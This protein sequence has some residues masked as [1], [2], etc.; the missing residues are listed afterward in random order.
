MTL[1][2]TLARDTEIGRMLL[3][4]VESYETE[5]TTLLKNLVER[6]KTGS[7]FFLDVGS[8][9]GYFPLIVNDYCHRNDVS[10]DCYAHEPT[11]VLYERAI[12]LQQANGIFY[13]LSNRMLGDSGVSLAPDSI[14]FPLLTGKEYDQIVI[15]INSMVDTA[16]VLAG[17]E[18][19]IVKFRPLIVCAAQA[20]FSQAEL[21]SFAT[22][23]R[24][25]IFLPDGTDWRETSD[26]SGELSSVAHFLVPA[27]KT[28]ELFPA[29]KAAKAVV[30]EKSPDRIDR[31][32]QRM[33][34]LEQQL[35]DTSARMVQQETL[36][37][38][39]NK[40]IDFNEQKIQVGQTNLEASKR[41]VRTLKKALEDTKA[42]LRDLQQS[43][44]FRAGHALVKASKSPRS[45]LRLPA[46]LLRV[47]KDVL[48]KRQATKD[49][50]PP[51]S[52]DQQKSQSRTFTFTQIFP[53]DYVFSLVHTNKKVYGSRRSAF[54]TV[55]L[56]EC[57]DLQKTAA[58]M[59]INFNGEVPFFYCGQGRATG[60][61]YISRTKLHIEKP[62][63]TLSFTLNA[64]DGFET[65]LKQATFDMEF[66]VTQVKLELPAFLKRRFAGEKFD[67][68]LYSDIWLNRNVDGSAVWLA[69]VANTL[70]RMGRVLMLLKSEDSI[71]DNIDPDADITYLRPSDFDLPAQ[72][73]NQEIAMRAIFE[74]DRLL[75]VL[76]RVVVRGTRT[77]ELLTS[78]R[79]FYERS[80]VYLTDFYR[81]DENGL[82]VPSESRVQ[83]EAIADNAA[84]FLMQTPEIRDL[85]ARIADRPI[86]SKL[87]PPLVPDD[88]SARAASC[89]SSEN[90]EKPEISICYAGKIACN[91]GIDELIDWSAR[92]RA[93]GMKLRVVII[94]GKFHVPADN[95]NYEWEM[96]QRIAEAGIELL[97]SMPRQEALDM[98]K[99]MDYAWCY[100]PAAL[101]ESTIEVSCKL[102]ESVSLGCRS[103]CYPNR[104][105]QELLGGDYPY[106]IG[107]FEE[108]KA[109]L[110]KPPYFDTLSLAKKVCTAHSATAI[111]EE[112]APTLS[113]PTSD[114]PRLLFAGHDFKF[115][116][117]FISHL[118]GRGNPVLV[119]EW[120]WG[121]SRNK[122]MDEYY[123]TH[124]EVVFCEWG[125]ANAVWYSRRNTM[126][127][128][129]FIRAHLQ[130]INRAAQKFGQG[131][132]IEN[133]TRVIFVSDRVR[134]QAIAMWGWPEEKTVV[135]PNFVLDDQF[136][137][138]DKDFTAPV[139]N[140]GMI[141]ITPQ[142]KRF[143]RAVDLLEKLTASG[144]EAMLHIKGHRPEKLEFMHGPAR[145][146]EL[147]YY[148]DTY[149]RIENTPALKGRVIF[150]PWGNDMP[151]WYRNIHFILSLSD[152]ESFH[153]AL[154]DGALTGSWPL[155][156]P[157]EEAAEIFSPDWIIDDEDAAV[158]KIKSVIAMDTQE[159]TAVLAKNRDLVIER[160]GCKS[161]FGQLMDVMGL[162]L[163]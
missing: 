50:A 19:T 43:A 79:Q 105:N 142:R 133:V 17:A 66:P 98:L 69:N 2:F 13:Q 33:E 23:N 92:L 42:Q 47:R 74:L 122:E 63:P 114:A 81:L 68:I 61:A 131:I 12:A 160:Y 57:Q 86:R 124:S 75:A 83:V 67:Y 8:N 109:L 84:L 159:R 118:K 161:V 9:I 59:R 138:T 26:L 70:A 56:P 155:V 156:L 49:K 116:D 106:F 127:K 40:I 45:F 149:T 104:I 140:L 3:R 145:A 103:F 93:E 54:I 77:A 162:G 62:M 90:G 64:P 38:Q 112:L 147:G 76:K 52:S 44:S 136:I 99:D 14:Y 87:L 11:R 27:D 132:A 146:K 154:A 157:W 37:K 97:P 95:P 34:Q 163:T 32:E 100:R 53:G 130:E 119:N 134:R 60:G 141:G 85:I 7:M 152:F 139:I 80:A 28:A 143:D 135:I 1:D 108:L 29:D 30:V 20:E 46:E 72:V 21:K 107:S 24:Y 148:F 48:N 25:A 15:L 123:Y 58:A 35:R 4:D 128:P 82:E 6:V 117:P 102:I 126:K 71:I 153:Y 137:F 73:L 120:A 16:S 129:L 10:L 125:L 115:V 94:A 31:I 39:L 150:A 89:V 144:V 22:D 18:K 158:A 78:T 121:E 88:L 101:E 36:N 96:R 55:Q 113:A 65:S 91:W 5:T 110:I 51:R 111:A 41:Q 151:H